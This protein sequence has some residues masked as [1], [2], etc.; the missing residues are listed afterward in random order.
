MKI[1]SIFTHFLL[2]FLAVTIFFTCI[3]FAQD[4]KQEV[5][6]AVLKNWP[7][8]YLTDAKTGKPTGFA[9]DVI[10]KVA[11]DSGIKIRFKKYDSWLKLLAAIENKQ[12]DVIPNFGVTDERLE[13][14][15]YTE[16]YDTFS[17][18]IFVRNAPTELKNVNDLLEKKVAVV[19]A[20]K[21]LF[22]LHDKGAKALNVYKSIEEAFFSLLSGQND[23]LVYPE[24]VVWRLADQSGLSEKIKV[25][26]EP[27]FEVKRG[28]AVRKDLSALANKLDSAT[29]DFLKSPDYKKIYKKWNRTPPPFWNTK[30]LIALFGL[31]LLVFVSAGFLWRYRAIVK[32]NKVISDNLTKLK[33]AEKELKESLAEASFLSSILE[34]SSQPFAIG[35]PD[36]TI[37]K[38]NLAFCELTGY[39]HDEL[40]NN[41]NW[42]ETLTPEKWRE[43]EQNFIN[44]LR[45]T[46]KPQRYEKDGPRFLGEVLV[47]QVL[48]KE[49]ELEY[50]YGFVTDITE[51]KKAEEKIIKQQ[52]NIEKAQE[53]G[54]IGTWELDIINNKLFW[55]NENCRIFGVPEDSVV[56]YEIFIEKVHPADRE[57][58]DREWKAAMEG[59]DYDIE[60]RLLAGDKIL[61]VR[62]KADVFFNSDGLAV[63]ALGFTQD[64]TQRRQAEEELKQHRDNLEAEVQERT[65]KLQQLVNLMA[66]RENRM[67]ELKK[68]IRKL[69]NQLEDAGLEPIGDDPLRKY[70]GSD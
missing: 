29:R 7:P 44:M 28:I 67:A 13:L 68:M 26:G 49:G 64:I 63:S 20:N 3:S 33:Q 18:S 54:Q 6:V 53:L 70:S 34:A 69:R 43:R 14:Y 9:V 39:S 37:K 47:N 22:I 65:E 55:T 31:I 27:I 11:S 8:Q 5:V 30:R 25:V 38:A 23:A 32:F 24:S 48:N 57:Y 46:G 62:E 66:G 45:K 51:R 4:Q 17:I 19:E 10:E 59:A 41:I 52:Y 2:P 40:V 42:T 12:A 16:P 1:R 56:N 50:L 58:V 36:G 61:W 35:Y 21:G 15:N 60:H